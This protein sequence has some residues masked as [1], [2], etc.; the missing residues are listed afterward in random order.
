MLKVTLNYCHCIW[1]RRQPW[2]PAIDC[3]LRASL[4]NDSNIAKWLAMESRWCSWSRMA[5]YKF[6][7]L[8]CCSPEFYGLILGIST[9]R[10]PQLLAGSD[11][12]TNVLSPRATIKFLALN[13][14]L[15]LKSLLQTFPA[16]LTWNRYQNQSSSLW[17][18]SCCPDYRDLCN[19]I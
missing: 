1:C 6:K 18:W 13:M 11:N 2:F 15:L 7:H 16:W 14:L 17:W 12:H 8:V 3:L 19:E 4:E 5:I 10:K 9:S